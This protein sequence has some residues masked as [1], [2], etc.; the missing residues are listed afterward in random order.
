MFVD[1]RRTLHEISDV[2]TCSWMVCSQRV[3]L[4][5]SCAVVHLAAS[6]ASKAMNF[7]CFLKEST[8]KNRD[9]FICFLSQKE[10][11]GSTFS[12]KAP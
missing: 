6:D 7:L 4:S 2:S 3:S 10:L 9:V 11:F 1:L 12:F 5:T 8:S